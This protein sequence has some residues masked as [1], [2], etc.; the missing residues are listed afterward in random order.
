M[1]NSFETAA[2]ALST[3]AAFA[4]GAV[5][6]TAATFSLDKGQ[7]G[8]AVEHGKAHFEQHPTAFRWN[9]MTD[10]GYGYPT[11]LMRTEYLAV[12]D[13]VR[14]AEFQRKY[15]SQRAHKLTD[16][17]IENAR[18]EVDGQ[19]QFLVTLYGPEANFV[20][21]FEFH[22]MANGKE[23]K[24]AYVDKPVMGENSG[25]KGKLAYTATVIIDFPTKD[26]K[27]DEKVTLVID[28]PDGLGPSGS[29][30]SNFEAPFDLSAVM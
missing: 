26:L 1:K 15:G 9:Y 4:L 7:L 24:P 12:S 3:F 28:P 5:S 11:V 29:R 2:L 13:Y 6:A 8:E 20:D 25:F 16:E 19:L 21:N 30:N 14:R 27:G 23:M 18:V 10:L 22:L 17:R